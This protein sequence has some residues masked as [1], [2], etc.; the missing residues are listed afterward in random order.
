[1]IMM[2]YSQKPLPPNISAGSVTIDSFYLFF[3][4]QFTLTAMVK[5]AWPVVI[6]NKANAIGAELVAGAVK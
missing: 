5:N 1:M 6:I 4:A 3:Q 2:V